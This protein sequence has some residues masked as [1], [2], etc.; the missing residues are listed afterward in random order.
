MKRKIIFTIF[1]LYN[2]TL[3]AN[4][5]TG[6]K[7]VIDEKPVGCTTSSILDN[8]HESILN[9]VLESSDIKDETMNITENLLSV[10]VVH[11]EQEVII[12]RIPMKE[13]D[14]CPPYCI[15]PMTIKGVVT[16]G[17]V[18]TLDFIKKLKEKKARLLIDVRENKAYKRNTIPGSIN[19]PS[20]ML[21]DKSPYQ[22]EVL[23]LL[24]A[25]KS[26]KKKSNSKWYFKNTQALLIFG[27]SATTKE[28]STVVKKLIELGYPSS[29]IF[30][31]RGG[32]ESW[33]ALGLTLF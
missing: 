14:T 13:I 7:A 18:E 22:E 19:L 33:K 8:S 1:L 5:E 3:L 9:K 10:N 20:S 32:L 15:E 4:S 2:F 30:Y 28:A 16:V 24:G 31:Y 27:Q 11:D 12:E 6:C 23:K 17:E 25:K 26:T 21:S 29:K